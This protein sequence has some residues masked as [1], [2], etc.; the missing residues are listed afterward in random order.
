MSLDSALL[1]LDNSAAMSLVMPDEREHP[2]AIRLEQTVIQKDIV[3]PK[4][5]KI[6]FANSLN[7]GIKRKRINREQVRLFQAQIKLLGIEEDD[8]DISVEAIID[9]AQQYSVTAYDACYLELA[10]RHKAILATNDKQLKAAAIQA[11]L[12]TI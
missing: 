9:L 10:I 2:D 11:R 5:W 12:I 7:M 6:E 8:A 1:V 4:L 3:V